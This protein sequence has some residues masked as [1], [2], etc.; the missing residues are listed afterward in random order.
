MSKEII[1]ARINEILKDIKLESK[2]E[3]YWD[4]RDAEWREV[5]WYWDSTRC[6]WTFKERAITSII[7]KEF[8]VLIDEVLKENENFVNFFI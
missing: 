1:K 2:T 5:V 8:S 6:D 3:K 7:Q 4:H